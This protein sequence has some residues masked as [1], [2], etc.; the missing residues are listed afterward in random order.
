MQFLNLFYPI[1][2]YFRDVFILWF[3]WFEKF[4]TKICMAEIFFGLVN[5]KLM[6]KITRYT[7]CYFLQFCNLCKLKQY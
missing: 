4:Y 3:L 2:G 6:S 7:V 5:E 1:A